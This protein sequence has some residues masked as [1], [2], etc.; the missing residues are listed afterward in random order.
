MR[1]LKSFLCLAATPFLVSVGCAPPVDDPDDRGP[2]DAPAVP[3]ASAPAPAP[4]PAPAQPAPVTGIRERIDAALT[5]VHQRDLLT[6]HSFWTIFHGILGTGLDATLLDPES[7]TRVNAIDYIRQG[8]SVRGLQFIPTA[9]GLDVRT[10]PQYVGQGHQ[11]Q[12][13]A[14][15]AQW[16]LP[17]DTKFLVLGK[18][19]TLLDFVR[20]TQARA[21]V[22]A[23][24]ELSWAILVIGQYV[25][26]KA[27][28]TNAAGEKLRFEDLVRYE[29]N[30]PIDS[31]PCGGTHRLFGLSWV[32]HLHLRQGGR[33][34]DV[35]KDVADRTAHYQKLAR[36][37]QNADGSFSTK[38]L[39]GPGNAQ[40][41]GLRI[42]TT[43][44][45]LEWLSL[46][47]PNAELRADWM[48]QAASTLALMILDSQ[49][50]PV[51][52]GAL[53]HAAHGLHL[54]RDRVYGRPA[55]A[56]RGSLVPLPP[57][58]ISLPRPSASR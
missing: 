12:F 53:Y 45:V 23:D 28:W 21:S 9:H 55:S 54:Y 13:V 32:Y 47:L 56:S 20:H 14:E 5:N 43:G 2:A 33:M 6:T 38:Y 37:Y 3:T 25:G 7:R 15:M 26:T 34:T 24:Q 49:G 42:G 27:E 51:E 10:G 29:L 35:W 22:T 36:Q 44:H 8:G 16:G 48:Q 40:E 11:D 18:E 1:S 57:E 52:G 50:Q 39:A 58:P 31:A 46:S 30:Q 17:A 4:A 41:M 19:Y